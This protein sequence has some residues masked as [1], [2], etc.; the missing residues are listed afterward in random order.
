[1]NED[2]IY[3]QRS[4]TPVYPDV[5][6]DTLQGYTTYPILDDDNI[7]TAI[8]LEPGTFYIGWEQISSR[9]VQVGVDVNSLAGSK[10]I[11]FKDN[12]GW[13]NS[14]L[15]PPSSICMR[16]VLGSENLISTSFEESPLSTSAVRIYP[17]PS[18]G[19]LYFELQEGQP[20]DYQFELYN[21][22]GQMLVREPLSN[23]KNLREFGEG[24][25]FIRLTNI[26][27]QESSQHKLFLTSLKK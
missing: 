9:S 15:D 1:M 17:N 21:T 13:L 20:E 18:S 26:N 7:R 8:G 25:F 6:F 16:A 12:I 23:Q 4:L 3:R 10:K 27:T 19:L 5:N 24:L 11:H 22:A 14:E 2:P